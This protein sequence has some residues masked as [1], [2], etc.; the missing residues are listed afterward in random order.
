MEAELKH[1]CGIGQAHCT[2]GSCCA[3]LATVVEPR[4]L[5]VPKLVLLLPFYCMPCTPSDASLLTPESH[6]M[7]R[8]ENRLGP[9]LAC[10][11]TEQPGLA[12]HPSATPCRLS[13][14]QCFVPSW[15]K[16]LT[17][18]TQP[19]EG[20]I[21]FTLPSSLWNIRKTVVNPTTQDL[22]AA[23]RVGVPGGAGAQTS[24]QTCAGSGSDTD[25]SKRAGMRIHHHPSLGVC[26][27]P[28]KRGLAH[29]VQAP[30]SANCIQASLGRKGL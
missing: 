28:P 1:R 25:Q 6:V 10:T 26:G 23:V 11:Q 4:G 29:D 21:T 15:T 8:Q 18:F 5:M 30:M 17:L 9:Y 13:M 20:D 7:T 27:L 3:V 14:L 12:A 19:W 24:S 16:W 22:Q 2:A